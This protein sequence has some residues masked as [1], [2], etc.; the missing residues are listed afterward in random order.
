MAMPETADENPEIDNE[1]EQEDNLNLNGDSDEADGDD[2]DEAAAADGGGGAD[3][4]DERENLETL[5]RRLSTKP[6]RFRVHDILIRG[7][8]KTKDSLIEAEVLDAFQKASTMQEI[9]HA[10]RVAGARLRGLGIFDAV[11][12]T[13]DAGPVELPGTAN[14]VIEVVEAKNPLTGDFGVY[15]RP[16][17]RAWSLEG[18][19]KLKN[20][21]GYG[22]FWNASGSYGWDQT[23]KISAEVSLPR[24]KAVSTPLAARLSLI[25]QDWLRFSSYKESQLGLSFGLLSTSHHDLAY[26]LAWRRLTDPSHMSSKSIRRQL[27]HNLISSVNYSYKIDRRDSHLRPTSGYAFLCKS[28]L[29]GLGP[30]SKS[31]R[32]IRQEIDLRGAIPLGFF[33]AALNVGVAAGFVTP[34][35]RGFMNTPSTLPERFFLGGHSSAVCGLGL[36]SLLGFEYRGLGPTDNR[37]LVLNNRGGNDTPDASQ[38]TDALG[39]D[40]ALTTYADLSFDLPLKLFKDSGIHG[41]AFINAGNLA[42][43]TGGEYKNFSL[44]KFCSTFR[45][46]TG[47]GLVIP[48]KLFRMEINY[49]YILR[50]FENDRGKTGIQFSFS[51][52]I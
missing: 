28:L 7:N 17:A 6:L 48:T 10:A 26:D 30:T 46:S 20:P 24:F 13:L 47:F 45:S 29:G 15:S 3:P 25:N 16:E 31:L 21:L 52:A 34:W 39:G 22:D 44:K 27:G 11:S 36:V 19:M 32:F 1:T 50:Q 40:L 51:S 38:G 14:V 43:L 33:N 35:G 5:I 37:I 42:R 18:S 4:A 8:T 12:I 9:L 2:Y 23:T 49:C 41:H